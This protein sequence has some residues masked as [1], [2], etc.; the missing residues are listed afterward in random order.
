MLYFFFFFVVVRYNV[1]ITIIPFYHHTTTMTMPVISMRKTSFIETLS[2][3][4]S[5]P[6][7]VHCMSGEEKNFVLGV[8][9]HVAYATYLNPVVCTSM[10]ATL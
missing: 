6:L 4:V 3:I 7:Y 5:T 2:R 10:V 8:Y 1:T 9:R